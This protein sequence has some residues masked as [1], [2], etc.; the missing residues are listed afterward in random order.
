LILKE[1]SD[2]R[3]SAGKLCLQELQRSSNSPLIMAISG[4]K[5]KLYSEKIAFINS[6]LGSNINISQMVACVGQQAISGSRVPNGFED[7]SLPHFE[8][9]CI[10]LLLS[11][12][13]NLQKIYLFFSEDSS[14]KRFC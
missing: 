13:I 4:S 11:I 5:G 6:V 8:K 3:E 1:L 14:C 10:F 2:V 9:H 7:R 12:Y